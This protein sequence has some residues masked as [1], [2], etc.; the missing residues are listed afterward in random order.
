MILP[1][2]RSELTER[3]T[4]FLVLSLV[5]RRNDSLHHLYSLE[6]QK[7]E[8]DFKK[9]RDLV[10]QRL[11]DGVEDRRRKIREDKESVGDVVAGESTGSLL[12]VHSTSGSSVSD[13]S[14][15]SFDTTQRPSSRLRFDL[16]LVETLEHKNAI[17][18]AIL[19]HN[20]RGPHPTLPGCHRMAQQSPASRVV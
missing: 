19:H 14:R 9:G 8:D 3:E 4:C 6:R 5:T 15:T 7:I 13:T 1:R 17:C 2:P 18:T 20:R 11:L 10:R 12:P 16:V